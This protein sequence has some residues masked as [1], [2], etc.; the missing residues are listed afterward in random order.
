MLGAEIGCGSNAC[1]LRQ[2][3][4]RWCLAIHIA[5][6]LL[7]MVTLFAAGSTQA[8]A[9]PQLVVGPVLEIEAAETSFYLRVGGPAESLP[10]DSY[11]HIRELPPS[12]TLSG[13]EKVATGSW[14]VELSALENLKVK[15]PASFAGSSD[16]VITL[17]DGGGGV[18]AERVIQLYVKP[19]SAVAPGKEAAQV[20][21][22]RERITTSALPAVSASGPAEQKGAP[23]KKSTPAELAQ[24]ERLVAHGR[25]YFAQGDVAVAR[26]Y[27]GR[28]AG[29]G[30][31]IAAF[32]LAET[33]DPYELTRISAHGLKADPAEA[34][35]WY[36]RAMQLGMPEADARLRRLGSR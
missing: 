24:A 23:A 10:R 1:R 29:L 19:A 2:N 5:I 36:E 31:P 4:M 20:Q 3:G 32:R 7:T 12:V 22:K 26:Q 17:F 14:L 35:R 13:G 6:A 30:L 28:A 9:P 11:I 25:Y 34:R 18:L 15:V 33:H 27:F 16:F 21:P 8:R